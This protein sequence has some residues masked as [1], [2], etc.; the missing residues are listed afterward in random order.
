MNA[1]KPAAVGM[2]S[3][4]SNLAQTVTFGAFARAL[5]DR[6]PAGPAS[7]VSLVNVKTADRCGRTIM[8]SIGPIGGGAGAGPMHDGIDGSGANNSF[9]K[10]TPIEITEAEVP[11]HVHRYGLVPDSGGAGLYRG[12]LGAEIEFQLFAPNSMVTARN[13]DRTRFSAWGLCDGL[14]GKPSSFTKNP[15]TPEAVKLGNSDIIHC[16]PGDII[17]LIG[18]GAG[19]YGDPLQRPPEKVLTDVKRGFVSLATARADYGVAI[20]PDLSL[21]GEATARLRSGL[22]A[23]RE[24]ALFNWGENRRRYEEVWTEARYDALTEILAHVVTSWRFFVKHRIF[25][26]LGESVA[27]KNGGAET[28]YEIYDRL[29]SRFVDL[30][31]LSTIRQ[32]RGA[33]EK[34]PA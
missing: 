12:G 15:N 27:P 13:R 2:R 18:P 34:A 22:A 30:P 10:N 5:P 16:D 33:R 8:A 4:L 14:A 32:K 6:M 1:E 31:Q 19:G 28:I 17:C 11:I 23:Q 7:A 20:G 29:A 25:R 26:E 21:D 24:H 9:L 3:L